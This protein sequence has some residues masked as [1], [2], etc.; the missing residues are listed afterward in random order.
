M[1][2]PVPRKGE[3]ES[4]FISR[5][6]SDD[7]MNKEYPDQSQRTAIC[8]TSWRKAKGIPEPKEKK[9]SEGNEEIK[10]LF[11]S[12]ISRGISEGKSGV[13]RENG[14]IRGFAV[15]TKGEA[16]GHGI[17]IDDV[18]LDQVVEFGNQSSIGIKSRFGHPTMSSEA[19]G[20]FLGRAKNFQRDGEVDR[21][22]L[23]IDKSAYNTPNGNLADYIMSLAE[24]DPDSFGSSIVF[25]G[26]RKEQLE[27]DGTRKK[28]KETGEELFPLVRFTK[29]LGVDAVDNPAA[30]K[31]M[32]GT[33]F[34]SESV[35]PSAEMTKFLDKFLLDQNAIE[36]TIKFL[37]R[38]SAVKDDEL[39]NSSEEGT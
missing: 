24:S 10:E 35:M 12:D 14:I 28:N 5:C 13:D 32:F 26:K 34:F 16:K 31:G 20:T 30:N 27:E 23:H 21:A 3:K 8:Y 17:E 33:Q 37:Q 4:V 22:D 39:A 11:R 15:V 6:L 1:P 25:E 9:H 29:L 2:I 19:L 7:I 18:A 38:Y 36:K